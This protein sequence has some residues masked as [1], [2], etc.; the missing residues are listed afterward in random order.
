MWWEGFWTAVLCLAIVAYV[1]GFWVAE[2]KTEKLNKKKY[3]KYKKILDVARKEVLQSSPW[4]SS[5]LADI[6]E[7]Y[8]RDIAIGLELKKRPARKAAEEV[9]S[10]AREKRNIKRE[11]K[12]AQY[13]IAFWESC[14][15]WLE[16]FK[17]V[18]A[19]TAWEYSHAKDNSYENEYDAMSQWLSPHEYQTL[20]SAERNQLALD[21]YN[22]RKKTDWEAGIEY[23]RYVGYVLE[24]QGC[25]VTYTGAKQGLQDMGRDLI[26]ESVDG[27]IYVIQCKRWSKHK[28]IHEKHIFQLFGTTTLLRVNSPKKSYEAVFYTT[29]ELSETARKCADALNVRVVDNFEFQPYPMIK[30]NIGRGQQKIYHLPM[31]QQYDTVQIGGK[32]GACYISTA[33]EAEAAGFRRAYRWHPG[34]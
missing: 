27:V 16:D 12:L 3:E 21:R 33:K 7:A 8:D 22:S 32:P 14:F 17:E 19:K 30:C 28:T 15:P 2:D 29:T 9:R 31:D 6:T 13:Q 5:Q 10:I 18:P 23:E 25:K 24:Q 1:A 20:S 11:L 26:A 4:L 34:K